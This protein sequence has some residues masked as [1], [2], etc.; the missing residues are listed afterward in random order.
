MFVSLL[1]VTILRMSQFLLLRL[2][3]DTSKDIEIIVLRH[4]LAALRRQ[5][6][7]LR[8]APADRA[9]L[10]LL[11]RLLPRIGWTA[12]AVTPATLLRWHRDMVRRKWTHPRRRPGRPSTTPEVRAL[13]Y[14]WWPRTQHGGTDASTA[15]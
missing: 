11:S 10:A 7:P 12:F 15:S 5:A 8:P 9:I 6:G 13:V 1:Y 3:T 4:Q 2:R 14:A